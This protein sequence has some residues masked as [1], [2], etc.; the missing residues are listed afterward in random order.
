MSAV[1]FNNIHFRHIIPLILKDEDLK[2][3]LRGLK[4]SEI[5]EIHSARRILWIHDILLP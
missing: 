3:D 1:C 5:Y 2:R 4:L